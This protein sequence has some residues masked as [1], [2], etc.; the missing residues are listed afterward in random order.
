MNK[1]EIKKQLKEKLNEKVDEFVDKLSDELTK[2][3]FDM[4][5]VENAI[6]QS[7]NNYKSEIMNTTE[8]LFNSRLESDLVSKKKENGKKKDTK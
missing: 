5:N 3:T 6:G 8:K 2:E 4:S 1:E 7:I